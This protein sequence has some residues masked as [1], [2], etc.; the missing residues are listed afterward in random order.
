MVPRSPSISSWTM[1]AH[2]VHILVTH[3]LVKL[4]LTALGDG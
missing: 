3:I 2:V 1:E 4:G